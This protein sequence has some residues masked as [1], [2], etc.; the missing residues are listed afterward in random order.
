MRSS[1]GKLKKTENEH[2]FDPTLALR[3]IFPDYYEFAYK[4]THFS[5][6][7]SEEKLFEIR[8]YNEVLRSNVIWTK[9]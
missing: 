5:T 8:F 9:K 1:A 3:N 6:E 2:F 4:R 7:H